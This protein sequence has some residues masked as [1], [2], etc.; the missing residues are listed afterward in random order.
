MTTPEGKVKDKIKKFMKDLFPTAW[1]FMPVQNGFGTHGVPDHIYCVPIV[2]T[3]EMVGETVGM[4]I[5]IEA[6]TLQGKMSAYQRVQRDAIMD[7]FGFYTTIYGVGDIE[8]KL[9][10]LEK[11]K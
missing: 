6:K 3:Q 2:I 9:K 8:D 11:L 5:G 7:A 1:Q 10:I 4:F